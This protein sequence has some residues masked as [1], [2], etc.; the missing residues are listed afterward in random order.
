MK[1][2]NC[3]GGCKHHQ[4]KEK[5]LV[6]KETDIEGKITFSFKEFVGYEH[7]CD[8]HPDRY[9]EFSKENGSKLST[10]VSENVVMDCYEPNDTQVLLDDMHRTLDELR[11]KIYGKY[12]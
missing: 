4:C 12:E 7:Y 2:C 3:S 6:T 9:E 11:N 8:K 1:G 10:W 5:Y